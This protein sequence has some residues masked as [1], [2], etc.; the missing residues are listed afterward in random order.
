MVAAIAFGIYYFQLKKMPSSDQGTTATQAISLTGVRADLM[1]IAQA[2]RENI[3]L[4]SQCISLDELLTSGSM[5][6][7]RKERDGYTYEVKCSGT[8]FQVIAEHPPALSGSG[9]RY[10]K[11]AIDQA[12]QM[13][14]LQ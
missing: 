5:S 12:M 7:N 10:P 1:Q 11:L 3:A 9:I 4:N 6:M 13:Q 14:E 2:E 8:D